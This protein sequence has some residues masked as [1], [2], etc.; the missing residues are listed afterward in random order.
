MADLLTDDTLTEEEFEQRRKRLAN[1]DNQVRELRG[2]PRQPTQEE[3]REALAEQQEELRERQEQRAREREQQQEQARIAAAARLEEIRPRATAAVEAAA[4]RYDE[5]LNTLRRL[6]DAQP[7]FGE[8]GLVEHEISNQEHAKNRDLRQLRNLLNNSGSLRS[9]EAAIHEA[10]VKAEWI[11]GAI[12]NATARLSSLQPPGTAGMARSAAPPAA[13]ETPSTQLP[14]PA[15]AP[16]TI[17]EL[18]ADATTAMTEV[19]TLH[20]ELIQLLEAIA[21]AQGDDAAKRRATDAVT[22]AQIAKRQDMDRLRGD[23]AAAEQWR[24]ESAISRAAVVRDQVQA[25]IAALKQ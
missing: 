7:S 13:G 22:R 12:D 1:L 10:N 9:L 24:I 16:P 11:Q 15:P 6:A 5:L 14:D 4:A 21:A 3:R 20:D 2:Q 17:D 8:R 25:Q 18:R 19:E 23:V